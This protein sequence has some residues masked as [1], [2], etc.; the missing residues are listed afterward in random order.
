MSRSPPLPN[1][2]MNM[3]PKEMIVLVVC[4]VAEFLCVSLSGWSGPSSPAYPP[5]ICGL[6]NGSHEIPWHSHWTLGVCLEIFRRAL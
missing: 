4:S 5:G 1:I 2:I 6:M 3:V